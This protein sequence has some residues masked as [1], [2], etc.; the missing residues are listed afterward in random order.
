MTIISKSALVNNIGSI[1]LKLFDFSD[2]KIDF[3][4]KAEKYAIAG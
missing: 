2:E 3:K 1:Q 4:S